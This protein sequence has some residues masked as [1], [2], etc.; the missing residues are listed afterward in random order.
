MTEIEA[1]IWSSHAPRLCISGNLRRKKDIAK[2]TRASSSDKAEGADVYDASGNKIG[3]IDHLM[4]DRVSGMVRYAIMTFGGFFGIGE[5][6]HPLPWKALRYDTNLGGY[7]ANVTEEQLQNAPEYA[8]EESWTDR[9]W[10]TRLNKNYGSAP[11]WED[12][13]T[14]AST[15]DESARGGW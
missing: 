3:E 8:G 11:Y 6:E 9:D 12:A 5:G 10:E 15:R 1:V 14:S 13:T 7:V 4:I 2:L